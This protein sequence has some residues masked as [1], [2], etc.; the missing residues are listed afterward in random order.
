M[1]TFDCGE[2]GDGKSGKRAYAAKL[3]PMA[4]DQ[5]TSTSIMVKKNIPKKL[6]ERNVLKRKGNNV[7]KEAE[8]EKERRKGKEKSKKIILTVKNFSSFFF[9]RLKAFRFPPKSFRIPVMASDYILTAS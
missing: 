9:F 3:A 7:K 8:K 2:L 4:N 5:K 1:T 6:G